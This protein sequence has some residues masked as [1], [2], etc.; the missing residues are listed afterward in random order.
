MENRVV[1][2]D[3]ENAAVLAFPSYCTA[4]CKT[5]GLRCL[6]PVTDGL[7]NELPV[8]ARE[9]VAIHVSCAHEASGHARSGARCRDSRGFSFAFKAAPQPP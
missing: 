8:V 3:V 2:V 9:S 5:I 7:R 1:T 6:L 4:T